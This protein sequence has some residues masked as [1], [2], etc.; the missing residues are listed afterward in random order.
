MST[1]AELAEWRELAGSLEQQLEARTA[2]LA[3]AQ[4]KAQAVGVILWGESSM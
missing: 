3:E 4:A 2:E 1:Q